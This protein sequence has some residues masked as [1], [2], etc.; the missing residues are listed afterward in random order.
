MFDAVAGRPVGMIERR[1]AHAHAAFELEGVTY[2]KVLEP[3]LR[4]HGFERHRER[5]LHHLSGEHLLNASMTREM[6]S[7]D[8]EGTVLLKCRSEERK[9]VDVV[10]VGMSQKQAGTLDVGLQKLVPQR[11]DARARI[12]NQGVVTRLDLETAG[13]TPVANMFRRGAS[14]ASPNAP[15]LQPER[16]L[17][18]APVAVS[19]APHQQAAGRLLIHA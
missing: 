16:H 2:G 19:R 11:S 8:L 18:P 5:G 14:D 13:V 9:T 6:P 10:P 12:Q 7:Q 3:Q 17:A 1:G 15:E 4:L